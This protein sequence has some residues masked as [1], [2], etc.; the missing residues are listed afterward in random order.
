MDGIMTTSDLI[1]AL[2]ELPP[3]APVMVAVVKYPEEF[4]VRI[5]EGEAN[6][7]DHTDV[8][9]QPLEAGE[10]TMINGVVHIAVEL[11]DYDAQRH[12]AGG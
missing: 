12:F 2:R 10:I 7:A 11:T 3:D 8:E 5:R 1:E 6:W 4:A 9:C